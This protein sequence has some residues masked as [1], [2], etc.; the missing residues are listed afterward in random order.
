ME[1]QKLAD[2]WL[3]LIQVGE[4]HARVCQ[5]WNEYREGNRSNRV[6]RMLAFCRAAVRTDRVYWHIYD[7][8]ANK[9]HWYKG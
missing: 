6:Q 4:R 9:P 3:R 2:R 5:W 8:Q 1:K 7:T